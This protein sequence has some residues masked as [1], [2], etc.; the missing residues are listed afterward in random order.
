MLLR[1]SGAALV[2]LSLTAAGY[3]Q[4]DKLRQRVLI[5]RSVAELLMRCNFLI[6]SSMPT[7]YELCSDLKKQQF[8]DALTF[9]C[10]LPEEYSPDKCFSEQ[11]IAAI[12]G[13]TELPDEEKE[14][15]IRLGSHLGQSDAEGQLSLLSSM[16]EE[17]E[18]LS[19]V[20]QTEYRERGKLCRSVW[21]LAGLM[22]AVLMI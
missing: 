3:K 8:S 16:L 5:S 4:A 18:T 22:A 14:L 6:R 2:A 1:L 15:L 21:T 19:S 7:V 11:W 20:R 10:Y 9:I 13:K 17:A 12:C